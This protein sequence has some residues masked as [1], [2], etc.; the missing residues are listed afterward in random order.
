MLTALPD[1]TII[2][3][4]PL[5]EDSSIFAKFIAMP[6]VRCPAHTPF[7]A[8]H[9]SFLLQ[10]EGVAVVFLERKALLAKTLLISALAPKSASLL[11]DRGYEVVPVEV[12]EFEVCVCCDAAI[13]W[14]L[15]CT[16]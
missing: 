6:E 15:T 4:K 13:S 9:A 2:G 7:P 11:R 10:A 5:L 3:Y 14:A 1:G 16:P 12:S 8:D